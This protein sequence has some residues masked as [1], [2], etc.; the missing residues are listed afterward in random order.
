MKY[1]KEIDG[2]RAIAVLAVLFFHAKIA[3]FS[4]GF[5]GVDIFFVI[6]GYL[7][8]S[9][10]LEEAKQNKFSIINFYE[11]RARRILPALS[12]VLF[13]TSIAAFY[14]LP[15]TLFQ[16]YLQSL[17]YVSTF[18]SN[19]FFYMQSDYFANASDEMP[20]LHTWSLA[21]E[22]QYYLFFPLFVVLI[23]SLAR[24][25]LMLIIFLLAV[26]SFLYSQYLSDLGIIEANFY[27]IF[28]RAWE[29]LLGSVIA[30]FPVE[31]IRFKGW[32]REFWSLL[33]FAMICYSIIS[34][35]ERTP[36]PSYTL[37]PIIGCCFV[38]LFANTSTL[39]G[40]ILSAKVFIF[41]GL[42]SY[43]LYLWHQPLFALIRVR[44]IGEPSSTVFIIAILCSV[45]L[46]SFSW[47]F[48]ETPFRNK[49][50]VSR[51]AIF[52]F[53]AAS[54]I[55]FFLI[56]LNGFINTGIKPKLE[57]EGRQLS[58]DN[59]D[60]M[61]K[62]LPVAPKKTDDTILEQETS[63]EI[64]LTEQPSSA[65]NYAREDDQSDYFDDC[66][67]QGKDYLRP[68]SACRYFK[69]KNI[70]WAIFGDSHT[71]SLGY[72]LAEKLKNKNQ[73][74]LHLSFSA[75][76]PALLFDA[77]EIGCTSWTKEAISYLE[78]ND[79]IE[80]VV[81]TYRHG[82]YLHGNHLDTYPQLSNR[83]VGEA[84]HE[85][86]DTIDGL[87]ESDLKS[88]YWGSFSALVTRLLD[89][90]KTVY[91]T[92]PIPELPADIDK[93]YLFDIQIGTTSEYYLA[94]HN[95]ILQKLDTLPYGDKLIAVNPFNSLCT[96]SNCPAVK[97]GR[98]LYVD[99]NHLNIYGA[100]LVFDE[101]FSD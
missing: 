101:I 58:Q 57:L 5:I 50:K 43:S 80:N 68:S 6:S 61:G 19:L 37:I 92:Y 2:L 66:D 98:L 44:T 41:I 72:A 29:L 55:I 46:A 49:K 23:L 24:T 97:N 70:N 8:T 3:G 15:R 20:L 95:Y 93:D 42:I 25:Y 69:E 83:S 64:R 59:N 40:R 18:S 22:E 91:I 67:A 90:G 94:R 60:N 21:I 82:L 87:T 47:K 52:K 13:C 53:S 4:G 26:A 79:Q 63:K 62:N 86:Y 48:I 85:R 100:S 56:G 36:F 76:P 16:E 9:I 96:R 30:F 11:R 75:C 14:Y 84:M 28:S 34:F 73:G 35:D 71:N 38:I 54:I 32:K 27:F 51:A 99:D 89:A 65:H 74:L 17:T 31:E 12:F 10:I 88:I 7:I 78:N 39:V 1:R 45:I 77:Q 81:V 33:G